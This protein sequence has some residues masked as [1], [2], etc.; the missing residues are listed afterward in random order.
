MGLIA[1]NDVTFAD[2]VKRQ[3][4]TL[5]D[6]GAAWCPPC[7]TLKPILDQLGSEQADRLAVLEVDCD[8]SPELA[9]RYGVMSMPTVLLFHDGEPVEKL[10]GLRPKASYEHLLA[11]YV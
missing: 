10:V 2:H 8:E 4:L 7:K 11:K 3:G 1:V 9:S 5:V 6:F